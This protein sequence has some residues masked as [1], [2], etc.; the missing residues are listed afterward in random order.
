MELGAVLGTLNLERLNPNSG[1]QKIGGNVFALASLSGSIERAQN[2]SGQRESGLMVAQGGNQVRRN[3]TL[4]IQRP[5]P[6]G[7]SKERGVVKAGQILVGAFVAIARET[8]I[9]ELGVLDL[10]LVIS[11]VLAC[12]RAGAPVGQEN[13]SVI[14]QFE[15]HFFALRLT[16]VQYDTL[17]VGVFKVEV[18]V[19]VR[20]GRTALV[21]SSEAQIVTLGRFDLDNFGTH[22]GKN[23]ANSRNSDERRH[24]NDLHAIERT[25][26]VFHVS[27]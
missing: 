11:E 27:S 25:L 21:R 15:Q 26:N 1:V 6:A 5:R 19:F 9:N 17:L 13:V 22:V 7:T 2:A 8:C 18:G 4:L 10:Q 3:G 24:F 14:K 20:V 12:E 16:K 23:T